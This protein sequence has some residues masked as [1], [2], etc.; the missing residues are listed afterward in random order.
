MSFRAL[1]VFSQSVAEVLSDNLHFQ[2]HFIHLNLIFS[3]VIGFGW[4]NRF[5]MEEFHQTMVSQFWIWTRIRT[6][7]RFTTEVKSGFHKMWS[8]SVRRSRPP[9]EIK[10]VSAE[11][12]EANH[13][14]SGSVRSGNW[15]CDWPSQVLEQLAKPG[16]TNYLRSAYINLQIQTVFY[17]LRKN[18]V[19]WQLKKR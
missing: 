13:K 1:L 14:I 16:I 6:W 10:H 5:W 12:S 9:A 19:N 11:M 2:I 15:S 3:P 7:E 18:T 4:W 17:T 8:T